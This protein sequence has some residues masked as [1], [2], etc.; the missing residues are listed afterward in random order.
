MIV[1]AVIFGSGCALIGWIPGSIV[2]GSR[3]RGARRGDLARMRRR[4]AALPVGS[5]AEEPAE[6][7][8]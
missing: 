1:A 5:P 2:G 4:E 3:R 6:L 8:A 7:S